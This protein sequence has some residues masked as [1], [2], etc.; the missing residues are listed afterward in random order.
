MARVY[1]YMDDETGVFTP[2]GGGQ[3]GNAYGG[4]GYAPRRVGY[5]VESMY[6]P[7]ASYSFPR[8]NV[9]AQYGPYG[10]PPTDYNYPP[11]APGQPR[12]EWVTG[13]NGRPRAMRF[14]EYQREQ[15]VA[16]ETMFNSQGVPVRVPVYASG[17]PQQAQQPQ[18][19][20]RQVRSQPRRNTSVSNRNARANQE[21]TDGTGAVIVNHNNLPVRNITQSY[22]DPMANIDEGINSLAINRYSSRG[23]DPSGNMQLYRSGNPQVAPIPRT[24]S[25]APEYGG[26]DWGAAYQPGSYTPLPPRMSSVPQAEWDDSHQAFVRATQIARWQED[27]AKKIWDKLTS[28]GYTEEEMREKMKAIDA[29]IGSPPEDTTKPTEKTP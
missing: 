23:V 29:A 25:V 5:G 19:P 17:A 7:N 11:Y 16:Y 22:Y 24:V 12:Y 6:N 9:N 2:V 26:W 18:Q 3:S 4:N 8:N 15:P 13:S 20:R 28:G 14:G 1:G 27:F 21:I 10:R